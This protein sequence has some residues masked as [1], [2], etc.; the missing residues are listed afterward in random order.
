MSPLMVVRES[1]GPREP[2]NAPTDQS[3]CTGAWQC[4]AAP[5][6]E[7]AVLFA[8]G[9]VPRAELSGVSLYHE[10]LAPPPA[11]V[12]QESPPRRAG[13]SSGWMGE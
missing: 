11:L 1:Q 9:R 7:R 3:R 4:A 13:G 8:S 12:R 6:T 2:L 10:K 5:I